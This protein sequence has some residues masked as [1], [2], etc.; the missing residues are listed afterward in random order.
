MIFTL[1]ARFSNMKNKRFQN[2]HGLLMLFQLTVKN[3][4]FV[5]FH[6]FVVSQNKMFVCVCAKIEYHEILLL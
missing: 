2:F 4:I 5:C 3:E 1:R 6:V